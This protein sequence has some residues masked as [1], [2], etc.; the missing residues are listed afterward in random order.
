M[1]GTTNRDYDRLCSLLKAVSTRHQLLGCI[2]FALIFA[3]GI[4]LLLLGSL[5][6]P[7]L[8]SL[9]RY[10]P[11]S[12]GVW[13]ILFLAVL[14]WRG[15]RVLWPIPSLRRT[16]RGLERT[17][18]ILRDDVTNT[19]LLIEQTASDEVTDRSSL[20]LIRAQLRRSVERVAAIRPADA[21]TAKGSLRRLALLVPLILTLVM[22]LIIDSPLVGRALALLSHP[23]SAIPSAPVIITLGQK[24]SF[25]VAR[26]TAVALRFIVAGQ[27]PEKLYV[28]VWPDGKEASRAPLTRGPG[29]TYSHV[30]ESASLSFRYQAATG[31]GDLSPLGTVRVVDP[32]DLESLKISLTPPPYTGLA[33]MTQSDGRITALNG[34]VAKLDIRATK[35]ISEGQI[36]LGEQNRY[37]LTVD[38]RHLSGSLLLLQ[39]GTYR[40][41]LKDTLGF[42]NPEPVVYEI[43]V[44]PDKFPDVVISAPVADMEITGDETMPVTYS[45][46]DDFGLTAIRLVYQ[47]R[48]EERRIV[49]PS[50]AGRRSTGPDTYK[51]DL[52]TLALLPGENVTFRIEA[53]DN[54]TIGGP[55]KA[56]SR[57]IV[58]TVRDERKQA[59]NQEADSQKIA[60]NL[61]NLLADQL[62]EKG[63]PET[64]TKGL[65]QVLDQVS[66]NLERAA[67]RPERFDLEALKRNLTSLKNRAEQE[68]KEKVTQELE[69]AALLA[70]DVTKGA[71]MNE[72]EA[73]ARELRNRQRQLIDAFREFKG[74]PTKEGLERL[75]AQL[76]KLEELL[77]TVMDALSRLATRLPDE[78]VNSQELS[79]MEFQDMFGDLS[80]MYRKLSEGDVEGALEAARRMLQ[81]LQEMMAS[82]GRAGTRAGSSPSDRM[83]GEMAQQASELEKILGEE[84]EI[85]S[86]TSES[87]SKENRSAEAD[88]L[89][90]LSQNRPALEQVLES[91]REALPE[92]EK[93]AIAAAKRFLDSDR[94]D[95]LEAMLSRLEEQ[96]RGTGDAEEHTA[97]R[98]AKEALRLTQELGEPK[99]RGAGG[100]EQEKLSGLSE[101]QQQLKSRTETFLERLEALAQLFPGM[102]TA[103]LKDIESAAG[104]MGSAAGKLKAAD[105]TGALPPE[106]DAIRRLSKSQQSMQQMSQQMAQAAGARMQAAG[107]RWGYMVAYDPRPG[108][109]YGPWMPMPTLPQPEVRFPREKGRTGIDRE[110]FEP[111]SKNAYRVPQRFRERIMESMKQPVPEGYERD[112]EHYFRGLAQ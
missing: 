20:A 5:A 55:K 71:R 14:A 2:E 97:E 32:P 57:S 4:S 111:P 8:S 65:D 74:P 86:E 106:E 12:Y 69:R 62:E 48:G 92:E 107:N 28:I 81:N 90:R 82:L 15:F 56:A 108:W 103:L 24:D 61:L 46:N 75:T 19:I 66:K 53:E 31:R 95:R 49:L 3:S 91:L 21:V 35:E 60:D 89:E 42:S 26:G 10:L 100:T 98:L 23:L 84:R 73:M 58:L 11:L 102:D 78:F 93:D 17:Y 36:V 94:L 27:G 59:A 7:A 72:V 96:L 85:R 41:G 80:E 39:P 1:A 88:T 54:D 9:S 29:N 63:T 33:A 22:V 51:W 40:I 83:A 101:R 43:R 77:R 105:A 16:A 47:V 34:T 25:V 30:I 99:E 70:E 112:V 104:S 37:P 45:A 67:D 18:P 13:S 50:A 38:G 6:L 79:G 52:S 76:K 87:Q 109:Y 68:P 44:I 110:E 64:L